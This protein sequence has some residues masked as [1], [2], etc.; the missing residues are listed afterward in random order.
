MQ[1]KETLLIEFQC[2]SWMIKVSFCFSCEKQ[3]I[4]NLLYSFDS[5][6]YNC[7]QAKFILSI[8]ILQF[9]CLVDVDRGK[10]LSCNVIV[11]CPSDR[12][13]YYWKK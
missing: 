8:C 5:I 13:L 9:K 11:K 6:V 10:S 2:L 7:F 1:A 3:Q 4:A 12:V